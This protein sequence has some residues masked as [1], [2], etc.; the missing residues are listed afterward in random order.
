MTIHASLLDPCGDR[1]PPFDLDL[2]RPLGAQR[3]RAR[4]RDGALDL[5]PGT[6]MRIEGG[7][8]AEVERRAF[9]LEDALVVRLIG[10]PREAARL[11]RPMAA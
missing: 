6:R 11:T 2:L 10:S 7:L 9:G 5:P 1:T 8:L 3:F 4:P